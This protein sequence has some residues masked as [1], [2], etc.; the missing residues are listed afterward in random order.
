MLDALWSR[1]HHRLML[2]ACTTLLAAGCT[3][4]S[5]PRPAA[6]RP[7]MGVTTPQASIVT[8]TEAT[9]TVDS[10]RARQITVVVSLLDAY[11]RGDAAAVLAHTTANIVWSDCDYAAGHAVDLHG[12]RVL[13]VSF[14][15]RSSSELAAKGHPDGIQPSIAAKVI[16]AAD[17]QTIESF[18]AGPVGGDQAPCRP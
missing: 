15:H 5:A 10:A 18:A 3:A 16:F 11:A 14:S 12:A 9:V 1:T 4:A 6:T 17:G 7:T 2:L 13:G 8:E